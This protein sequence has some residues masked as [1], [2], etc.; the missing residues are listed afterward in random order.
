V[1]VKEGVVALFGAEALVAFA[2]KV[3]FLEMLVD[4]EMFV[5]E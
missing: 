4:E 2:L 5:V 3:T 1:V